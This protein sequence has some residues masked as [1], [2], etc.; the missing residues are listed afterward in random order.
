MGVASLLGSGVV[1]GGAFLAK[2]GENGSFLGSFGHEFL[3][4][5]LA[6]LLDFGANGGHEAMFDLLKFI[7]EVV[8]EV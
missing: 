1:L 5:L 4:A 6:P 7:V 2:Q 3:V 8:L